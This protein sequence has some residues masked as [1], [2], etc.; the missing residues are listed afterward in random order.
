MGNSWQGVLISGS[1]QD[2]VIGGDTAGTRNLIS[3]NNAN[4][5]YITYS[6]T[7]G[8]VLK[9][10][11]IGTSVSGDSPLPNSVSG[12]VIEDGAQDNTVGPEN[13]IAFNQSTG[14][15][16]IGELTSGNVITQNSI[17]DNTYLGINLYN[18]ANNDIA[19]P[20]I[21]SVVLGPPITISGN[22][23][24]G[25]LVEVFTNPDAD[26]EGWIYLG[27][28]T[29]GGGGTWTLSMS[30]LSHPYLTATATNSADGT[31][32]FSIVY[33]SGIRSLF[34]PLIMR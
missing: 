32:E 30:A 12:V 24:N 10:N 18:G 33:V 34:L 25:C 19:A 31:S 27:S 6:N 16:V 29:A 4:G 20:T 22:A 28:T 5:V 3:G 13:V 1:A 26:G 7:T 15:R 17:H 9:R 21:S 11:L 8:N 23:C 2:N 14:V